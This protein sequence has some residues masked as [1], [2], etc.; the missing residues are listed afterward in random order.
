MVKEMEGN[1][2]QPDLAAEGL[3]MLVDLRAAL[4]AAT[5]P[6]PPHGED[7][8]HQSTVGLM[9]SDHGLVDGILPGAPAAQ[10]RQIAPGD[11]I[12]AVDGVVID[13]AERGA[14]V[15]ELIL[16]DD[17]PG[18]T[19]RL[20]L[21]RKGACF[22]VELERVPTSSTRHRKQLFTILCDIK[23]AARRLRVARSP[24]ARNPGESPAREADPGAGGK[25]APRPR[26]PPPPDG[27]WVSGSD[28]SVQASPARA[29][30]LHA[31]EEDLVSML[32]EALELWGTMVGEEDDRTNQLS[33]FENGFS[34]LEAILQQIPNSGEAEESMMQLQ[35]ELAEISNFLRGEVTHPLLCSTSV[36]RKRYLTES[37]GQRTEKTRQTEALTA[38]NA[39]LQAQWEELKE[40]REGRNAHHVQQL[41]ELHVE[42]EV[43]RASLVEAKDLLQDRGK[44]IERLKA[45]L[46]SFYRPEGVGVGCWRR[47][48]YRSALLPRCCIL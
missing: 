7:A 6:L 15:R 35:S 48:W 21:L 22:S 17:V 25:P 41:G 47:G 14:R 2:E 42:L 20:D 32:D 37:Y 23:A 46:G 3:T 1:N 36:R 38:T 24:H 44:E 19:V 5:A 16:G 45:E 40:E 12:L 4:G 43:A 30:A 39:E 11:A 34:S 8:P 10:S 29:P 31:L 27:E 9:V 13:H 28:G 33:R 26:T 18:S